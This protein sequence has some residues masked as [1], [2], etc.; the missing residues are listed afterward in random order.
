MIK[1]HLQD[2]IC[3][4]A[5]DLKVAAPW[6][7]ADVNH[8]VMWQEGVSQGK[9]MLWLKWNINQ[10]TDPMANILFQGLFNW[11]FGL[12]CDINERCVFVV[13]TE[14]YIFIVVAR[15]LRNFKG[16]LYLYLCKWMVSSLC[17]IK[18]NITNLFANSRNILS[19]TVFIKYG[20]WISIAV[21]M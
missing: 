12:K 10:T 7:K 17:Y 18:N 19:S 4:D 13:F 2:V 20:E 16:C 8:F 6:S 14:I 5:S 9:V 11:L 21:S 15:I 3:Y 1:Q